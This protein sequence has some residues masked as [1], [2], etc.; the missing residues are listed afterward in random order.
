VFKEKVYSRF[1]LLEIGSGKEF[2][3]ALE[4]IGRFAILE[5]LKDG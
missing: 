3:F 4:K 1:E 5:G 2:E